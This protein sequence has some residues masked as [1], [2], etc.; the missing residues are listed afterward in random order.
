MVDQQSSGYDFNVT[1]FKY[2]TLIRS[3]KETSD[4]QPVPSVSASEPLKRPT[5]SPLE[6]TS[7]KKQDNLDKDNVSLHSESDNEMENRQETK[8]MNK[9]KEAKFALDD[10]FGRKFED[11]AEGI[12]LM[13]R[14]QVMVSVILRAK[15]TPRPTQSKQLAD[16]TQDVKVHL[17]RL[18]AKYLQLQGQY[19]EQS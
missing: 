5:G 4:Q 15:K 17:T 11:V 3:P 18:Q 10:T 1:P 7:T 16:M 6:D 13:D 9:K 14:I 8:D 12:Q 19:I 2:K